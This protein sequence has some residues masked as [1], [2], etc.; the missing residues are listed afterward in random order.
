MVP[1]RPDGFLK[2]L[3][4]YEHKAKFSCW[5]GE[6]CHTATLYWG[7]CMRKGPESMQSGSGL[8]ELIYE[9]PNTGR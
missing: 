3:L 7:T 6:R 2:C 9:K 5:F 4:I 1:N 8:L